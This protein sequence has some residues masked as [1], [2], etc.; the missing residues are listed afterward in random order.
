VALSSNEYKTAE[1]LK[2]DYWLYVVYGCAGAPHVHL[3]QDPARLD[4]EPVVQVEHYHLSAHAILQE[5][6]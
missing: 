6:L 3:V 1:R 5:G 2:T 4:W